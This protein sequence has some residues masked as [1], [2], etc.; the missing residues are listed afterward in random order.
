MFMSNKNIEDIMEPYIVAADRADPRDRKPRE[1]LYAMMDRYNIDE[2]YCTIRHNIYVKRANAG[3]L[4]AMVELAEEDMSGENKQIQRAYQALYYAANAGNT[5]AMVDLGFYY[6]SE[7]G[8]GENLPL[9]FKWYMLAATKGNIKAIYEVAFAYVSGIG[10]EKNLQLAKSWAEN[11]AKM[12]SA[13]CVRLLAEHIYGYQLSPYY[14]PITEV[15]LL[16]SVMRMGYESEYEMAALRLGRIFGRHDLFGA[17][18]DQFSDSKKAAY[19]FVLNYFV[20]TYADDSNWETINKLN[21]Y[22]T[23]SDFERWKADA[24]ELRYNPEMI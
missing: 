17:P 16:E 18:K 24:L 9:A 13:K 4:Q 12:G 21:Y 2:N 6:S 19:C 23:E 10:T 1:T 3:D 15:A 22:V 5:N 20:D 11:G 8:F 7:D 14:N